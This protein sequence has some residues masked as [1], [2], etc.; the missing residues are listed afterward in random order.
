MEAY[1]NLMQRM[2]DFFL[3]RSATAIVQWDMEAYM[4]PKGIMLRSEQLSQL[5]KM[6]H[7]MA[8]DPE[9][10]NLLQKIE[11]ASKDLTDVQNR[12]AFIT[13]R[14]YDKET[15]V[16]EELVAKMA[17]QQAITVETWK[18][19][20]AANDWKMFQPELQKMI[21]LSRE[22][23]KIEAKV[24]GIPNLYDS[25]LDE[26]ERGL[27]SDQ[28]TK[29]FSELRDRLVPLTKK[30]ADAS[31]DLDTSFLSRKVPIDI[32]RK[33]ATDLSNLMG[34][35]TVSEQA[36]G[37]ID[38]VEHPFTTGYYDDVRIT[39]KYHEDNVSSAIYAILHEGG[40]ALYEQNLNPEWMY[41]AVGQNASYGVHESQSRFIENMIGRSPEFLKFYFPKLNEFTGGTF[42]DIDESTFIKAMNLVK[43][44][45]IRIEADEVTYSLHIIIRYEIERDLFSDKV[46]VSELPQVWN[47]KYKEYLGVDVPDDTNGV[48]Q[49]THWAS[50]YYGYF[51]SYALGNIYDGMFLAKLNKDV[52][53][54]LRDAEKGNIRPSIEWMMKNVHSFSALHDPA[55]LM[56]KVTGSKLTAGP[57]LDYVEK[58]Y[59]AIFG[60]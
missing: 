19:A 38:E 10:E 20:K 12:N 37:R 8:T 58:K 36:G 6:M 31:K 41:T 57:F 29:V 28:V 60:F 46:S 59:S 14:E 33:I 56:E 16:P 4:P 27:T 24:K 49:D 35:D 7:R 1:D 26:F 11:V 32:Q 22:R 54:W 52:P 42:S 51:P 13:R 30:C 25:M 2:K 40:H 17:R 45:L 55:D 47:E 34:Y 3:L 18:K 43:P 21:D 9:I 53:N 48:L 39:V 44:S 50:G 5:Y 15:K 23:S